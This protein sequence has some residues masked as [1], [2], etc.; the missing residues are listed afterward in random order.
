MNVSS[1]EC[2]LH[3]AEAVMRL[4][5]RFGCMYSISMASIPHWGRVF[6]AFLM[7]KLLSQLER[8]P[9]CKLTRIALSLWSEH[10]TQRT[11]AQVLLQIQFG[12]SVGDRSRHKQR[13]SRRNLPGLVS[14]VNECYDTH[15]VR[16]QE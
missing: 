3:L 14:Y 2:L 6:T 12:L 8:E 7:V 4:Q 5:N 11:G 16:L 10:R 15:H 9:G 13:P 1:H